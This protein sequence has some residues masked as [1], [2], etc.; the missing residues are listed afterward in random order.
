M[1]AAKSLPQ[2]MSNYLTAR[3]FTP[4][5]RGNWYKRRWGGNFSE[6]E[7]KSFK[8]YYFGHK[9]SSMRKAAIEV[10]KYERAMEEWEK[11][12]ATAQAQGLPA[13][14]PPKGPPPGPKPFPWGETSE[15]NQQKAEEI[16]NWW[17][18]KENDPTI[19]IN[20]EEGLK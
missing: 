8:S 17:K 9:R 16:I 3:N 20:T 6:S 10:F 2:I 7:L 5:R 14:K 19:N 1:N 15:D 13:P 4:G 18:E 12:S 11:A